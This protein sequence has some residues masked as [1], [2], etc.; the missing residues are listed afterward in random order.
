[1]LRFW[2]LLLAGVFIGVL[3]VYGQGVT[4]LVEERQ[5]ERGKRYLAEGRAKEAKKAFESL[6]EDYPKEPDLHLFFAVASFRLGD[7]QAA[8]LHIKK[9]LGIS[10]D[11]VEARTLL[12]WLAMEVHRDFSAAIEAYRRV[13]ELRPNSPQ[14]H[15]N[16]GVAFKK[17]GD[18]DRA[19][20]SFSRALDLREDYAEA[21][22]NRGW[23]Y[24]EQGRWQ[25]AREDFQQVL[26]LNSKD[27]GALYGLSRVLRKTRDYAGA[28]VALRTLIAHYSNFVYWLEWAEL[29]LVRYY[30]VLL[31]I[32]VGFFLHSRYKKA[33][34]ESYGG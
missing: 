28:H 33:R 25:E 15:N 34:A 22:S 5:W 6:F 18:L 3:L 24:V 32:A 2:A 27:E 9:T 10:P 4:A 20:E 11:H 19:K 30:W 13:V 7:V 12:G 16:L 17:N 1:M 8:E 29:Q 26:R 23:V 14:A 21:W 31:L